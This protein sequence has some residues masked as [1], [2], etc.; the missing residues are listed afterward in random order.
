M[1]L[2]RSFEVLEPGISQLNEL[3]SA[4]AL[5][6][7]FEVNIFRDGELPLQGGGG[8]TG[9]VM[10]YGQELS[11]LAKVISNGLKPSPVDFSLLSPRILARVTIVQGVLGATSPAEQQYFP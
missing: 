1:D 3:L 10:R 6:S 4:A 9:M 5:L 7:G 8:L 2:A 11:L